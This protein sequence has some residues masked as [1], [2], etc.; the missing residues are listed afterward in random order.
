LLAWIAIQ[1]L[2]HRHRWDASSHRSRGGAP[3]FTDLLWG[4]AFHCSRVILEEGGVRVVC[5]EP[6]PALMHALTP[7]IDSDR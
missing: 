3:D 7:G 1:I 2:H 6:D 5:L 4:A